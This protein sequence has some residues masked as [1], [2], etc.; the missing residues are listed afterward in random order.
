MKVA[1]VKAHFNRKNKLNSDGTGLISIEIYQGVSP[2]FRKLITTGIN[3]LPEQWNSEQSK[4]VK[5]PDSNHLN[6][7]LRDKVSEIE[8]F[9]YTLSAQKQTLTVELLNDFLNNETVN[10]SSFTDF[11]KQELNPLLK[12]GTRKEHLYTY[13]VLK[14]FKPNTLFSEINIGWV[15]DFEKFLR[16]EKGFSQNTIHKHHAHI[17]QYLRLAYLKGLFADQNNPYHHFKSKKEKS[18]RISLSPDELKRLEG[19]FITEAYPELS[20]IRD[21]FLFSCY[22]GLRYSDIST[23]EK[24]HLVNKGQEL[25]IVKKMEKVP[26]PVT[27]PLGLLFN[28]KALPIIERY[29]NN[30]SVKVFQTW[31]N[32][33]VNR[34]LKLLA[35]MANIP[36]RLTFHIARHTFGTMLADLTQNPYLIMDLMGHSDIDTSMIYIHRSQER[37]NKQLRGVN[38]DI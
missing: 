36:M 21:L 4:V 13:N 23:L 29:A 5:H 34:N 6:K 17:K 14:E 38:W 7:S 10:T 31:S 19:L 20:A 27:L 32:Q 15:K 35:M 8:N 37:I 30:D 1:I 9:I 12:R 3:V 33:H 2:T 26:K 18:D 24:T 28:G 11:Y 16:G 25:T 22:T